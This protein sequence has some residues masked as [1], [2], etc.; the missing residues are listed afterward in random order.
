MPKKTKMEP[1]YLIDKEANEINKIEKQV[2]L[3]VGIERKRTSL[4]M[5]S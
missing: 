2:F 4:G 5:D 1:M 3:R